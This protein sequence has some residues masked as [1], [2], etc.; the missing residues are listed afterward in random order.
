MEILLILAILPVYLICYYVYKK[1]TNKEPLGLLFKL[2]FFGVLSC[3]PVVF[4][5]ILLGNLFP[6]EENMNVITLF[7]YYLIVVAFVEE[8]FKFIFTYFGSYNHREFT[9]LYDMMIYATFV[10][11]GFAL[12]ENILY[13]CQ[14]SFH[15]GIFVGILRALF[16]VPGHACFGLMMG[17]FLGLSKVA[18]YN[19]NQ[20]LLKKNMA[21]SLFVP[22]MM[23]TFYDFALSVDNIYLLVILLIYIVWIY[24]FL[25]KKIKYISSYVSDFKICNN[26][27]SYCGEKVIGNFCSKCGRKHN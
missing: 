11:L 6:T 26:Y 10:S 15:E 20:S 14:N 17:Y 25:I 4:F 27:C 19:N 5:E 7:F 2:L 9:N 12:F 18:Q 22:I 1:D 3:F 21:L 23:H 16:A 24:I 13:V 8:L